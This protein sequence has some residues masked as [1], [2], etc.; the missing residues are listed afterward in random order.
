MQS[1]RAGRDGA[2]MR[3]CHVLITRML[4]EGK[5]EN[6]RVAGNRLTL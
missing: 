3:A 2:G 4:G 1:L 5:D 6:T